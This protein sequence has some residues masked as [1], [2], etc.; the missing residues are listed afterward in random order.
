MAK[1]KANMKTP[2]LLIVPALLLAG[3][4]EEENP[5]RDVYL[6]QAECQE[7]WQKPELC[8]QMPEDDVQTGGYHGH[9]STFIYW[10]PSYYSGYRGVDYNGS[11]IMPATNRAVSTP[12]VVKPTSSAAAKTTVKGVSSISRGGFGSTAKGL[13]GGS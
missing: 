7:D 6:T 13:S 8:E 11:T 3:C 5:Q 4:G 1:D 9:S 2:L 10:G 12:F